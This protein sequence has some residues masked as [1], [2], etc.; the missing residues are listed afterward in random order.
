MGLF[1]Q[2]YWDLVGQFAEDGFNI[3]RYDRVKDFTKDIALVPIS[4]REGEGIQDLLAVVI[5][6][7]ERYLAD[8]LTD[9]DGSGEG[10]NW[11]RYGRRGVQGIGARLLPQ[12]PMSWSTSFSSTAVPRS[13]ERA[14]KSFARRE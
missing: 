4:A 2:R 6:L 11:H 9:I 10:S 13:A 3:E 7:A 14:S 1:E 5:G 8:Q 12:C